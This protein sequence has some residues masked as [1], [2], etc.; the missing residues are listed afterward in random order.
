MEKKILEFKNI[1]SNFVVRL[2][3]NSLFFAKDISEEHLVCLRKMANFTTEL[4]MIQSNLIDI[5]RFN[6]VELWS[7]DYLEKS[8]DKINLYLKQEYRKQ[9]NSCIDDGN[10]KINKF[11]NLF[12][13]VNSL[14]Q[15]KEKLVDCKK[16]IIDLE[17]NLG[18][19]EAKNFH[20]LNIKPTIQEK[21][22][23]S[24]EKKQVFEVVFYSSEIADIL[25]RSNFIYFYLN[26]NYKS[27][28]E[29]RTSL[30]EIKHI[31]TLNF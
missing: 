5:A 8:F 7:V 2:N 10:Y 24:D 15:H 19:F 9:L 16:R 17:N 11:N 1:L 21:C 3:V 26:K 14:N 28:E 25:I 27:A 30:E 6:N 31:I 18:D 4:D 12:E 29:S 22:I 20:L 23:S 13:K